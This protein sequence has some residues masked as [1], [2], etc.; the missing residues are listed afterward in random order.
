[1]DCATPA[2]ALFAALKRPTSERLSGAAGIASNRYPAFVTIS[3]SGPVALP[4]NSR[5]SARELSASA[6]LKAG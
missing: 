6:V 2:P 1:M 3:L 4:M 5:A